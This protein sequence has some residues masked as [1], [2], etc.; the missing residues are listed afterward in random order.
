[1]D[2]L[3]FFVTGARATWGDQAVPVHAYS[4]QHGG[5]VGMK[6]HTLCIAENLDVATGLPRMGRIL[7]LWGAYGWLWALP[8]QTRRG[9]GK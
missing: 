2:A 1:M 4:F 3:P 6:V 8:A 5:K 9:L 7:R